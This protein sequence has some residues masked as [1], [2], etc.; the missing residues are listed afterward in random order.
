MASKGIILIVFAWVMEIVGVAGGV[1]NSS[2]TT[3]GE[4]LPNTLSGT[5]QQ[6]PC[7]HWQ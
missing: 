7:S 4:A 6:C 1:L 5:F 2:Y 3:F